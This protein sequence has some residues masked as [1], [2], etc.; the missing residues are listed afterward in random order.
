[1]SKNLF[2]EGSAETVRDIYRQCRVGNHVR[3]PFTVDGAKKICRVCSAVFDAAGAMIER[4]V[5][6]RE[7]AHVG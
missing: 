2:S 3:G 4:P 5:Y 1:M 6:E 7:K